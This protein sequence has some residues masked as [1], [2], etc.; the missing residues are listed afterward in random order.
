MEQVFILALVG[1]TSVGAY[2]V[3]A[4]GLGLSGTGIR[5]AVSKMLECLGMTL[6]FLA[7]NITVAVVAILAARVLTRGFVSLYSA[8]DETL[9][10]LSLIQGLAFQWWRDL[11]APW[12][13][14]FSRR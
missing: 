7:I 11:S 13:P 1:S 3:G 8:A 5:R 14:N 4:K 10:V 12:P 6:V 2:L 9:L